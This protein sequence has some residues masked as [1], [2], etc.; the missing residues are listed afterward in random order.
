MKRKYNIIGAII[1]SMLMP[2]LMAGCGNTSITAP[3]NSPKTVQDY[4]ITVTIIDGKDTLDIDGKYTGEVVDGT[5]NGQGI[6]VAESENNARYEYEGNFS[7][8]YFDG[9]GITNIT[10]DSGTL[11]M[12]GTYTRGEFTPTSGESFNYIGQLDLFGKFSLSDDVIEYININSNL[13]PTVNKDEIQTV[14]TQEFSSKQFNKTRKQEKIGLVKIDLYAVQVFED[15]YMDGKLTYIL[16][17]DDEGSYYALYYLGSTDVYD[18]DTFTA[19]AVP[20][21]TSSFNNVGGGT[22]NVIVMAAS[23]IE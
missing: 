8:G 19:Y 20:C 6:F 18:K 21:A 5:P 17:V 16:A 11:Q 15:D 23:Y 22:T 1:M 4:D 14:A 2:M 13:F 3:D 9:Y 12:A 7:S 10:N